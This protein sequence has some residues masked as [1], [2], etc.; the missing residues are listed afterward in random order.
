M[1]R[2]RPAAGDGDRVAGDRLDPHPG[3]VDP[4]DGE[5][6]DPP[7]PLGPDRAEAAAD[8]EPGLP[9]PVDQRAGRRLARIEDR[10]HGDA[11]RMQGERGAIGVVVV[12]GD[13]HPVPHGD[14]VEVEEI[15][16]RPRQHHAGAVVAGEGDGALDGAGGQHHLLRPDPPQP[17]AQG[18]A[19][20]GRLLQPFG[21][22][23]VA[24]VVDAGGL[25]VEAHHDARLGEGCDLGLDPLGGGPPVDL[26]PVGR[27]AAAPVGAL[28]DQQHLRAR[29]RRGPR[30]G[31]A[32]DAAP[33][34]QHVGEVVE[35]LV[36]IRIR[37][38]RRLAEARGLAD[39]RLEHMLPRPAG[40]DEG[41][42][43][44]ARREERGG[45]RIELA[46][47][48]LQRGPVVLALDLHADLEL[49]GGGA[50]V[51]G[52]AGAGAHGDQRVGLLGGRA[53]HPAGPVVL[54]RPAHQHPVV[55]EQRRGEGVAGDAL[56]ALAVPVEGQRAEAVDEATALR[57]TTG[58]QASSPS[59]VQPG[60]R[61]WIFSMISAGGA[62]TSAG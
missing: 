33:H 38:A 44:E 40:V 31:E 10:G 30:G 48:G 53:H 50:Q 26:D 25:G 45:E 36:A 11:G 1:H 61:A 4:A 37:R 2:R 35:V 34:H 43:V 60:R 51:R 7:M 46:H 9:R 39:E 27:R 52:A 13:H 17:L 42:V 56:Q 19:A 20:L 8:L 57:Q 32:R 3:A 14:A 55:G 24:V 12:G 21:G 16:R 6:L 23:D 28:L 29:A 18:G 54:E 58:H 59:G 62:E 5:R 22:E 41:L 15:A 47:V 49:G